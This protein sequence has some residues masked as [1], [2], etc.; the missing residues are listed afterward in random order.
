M[1]QEYENKLNEL[2]DGLRDGACVLFLGPELIRYDG[3]DYNL[4]F[5][6]TL[7]AYSS[8]D[9]DKT[10]V[11]YNEEEKIWSFSSSAVKSK[12]Y[13]QLSNFLKQNTNLDD[14][15]FFKLAS[16]PFTLIVSLLPDDALSMA[17]S[18]YGKFNFTFKSSLESNI[19]E[20][21]LDNLVIYNI[22]GNIK[23]REYVVSHFDYLNFI[24]K[25]TA[26][27]FP[28]NILESLAKANYLIFIGFEFDRWYNLFLLY[29][30]NKIKEKSDKIAVSAQSAE[31]L[32]RNL[33]DMN[34]L[35]VYF[36][37]KES[38]LFIDDLYKKAKE[39]NIARVLVPMKDYLSKK[40]IEIQIA[41]EEIRERIQLSDPLERKKFE[42]DLEQLEAEKKNLGEH[43]KRIAP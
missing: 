3:Q 43:L 40:I 28:I 17:F 18:N 9:I 5:Y 42:L 4:A 11:K 6:N 2:V 23:N 36:N 39:N 32:Y 14:P 41:I 22:Y 25:Y 7:S 37:E 35:N 10:K 13:I 29:I 1:D 27:G 8:N 34:S 21:S 24:E 38:E 15:I 20:P 19:P 30:L 33:L 31:E 16:L 26:K 12:F